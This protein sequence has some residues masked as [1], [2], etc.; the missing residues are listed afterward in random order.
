VTVAVLA[1]GMGTPYPAT[2]ADLLNAI[3]AQGVIASEWPPGRHVSRLRLLTRNRVVAA[4]AAGTVVVE[5][6][7]R[8]GAVS[9]TRHA[10]DLG[11]RLMAVPGPVTSDPSA[12]CHHVIRGWHGALRAPV[13]RPGHKAARTPSPPG[14]PAALRTEQEGTPR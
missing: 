6:G 4:L 7:Q 8:S 14:S 10:R 13:P 1:C 5:A 9:T 3:A 12:G 2:H 11:R